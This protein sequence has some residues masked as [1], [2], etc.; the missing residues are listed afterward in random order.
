MMSAIP[1]DGA[2][3]L[4]ADCGQGALER[5]E[6]DRALTGDGRDGCVLAAPGEHA[7]VVGLAAAGR[8]EAGGGELAPLGL[9]KIDAVGLT[10]DDDAT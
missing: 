5:M 6:H 10:H 1:I 8:V 9:A 3:H 2:G 4:S 7:G